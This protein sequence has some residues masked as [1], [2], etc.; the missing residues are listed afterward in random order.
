[1]NLSR[2]DTLFEEYLTKI[3]LTRSQANSIDQMLVETLSLFAT[4]Y[5]GDV[6]IYSQG[7]YAMGTTVRPLTALQSL[8]GTAGEYDVDIVLER[9]TWTDAASALKD[10]RNVLS[11]EYSAK[12][13]TKP[14]ESCERVL[15]S[16][17]AN[18]E[19]AFH[20][21]YV[22]IKSKHP[23]RYASRRSA[24]EWF[25]SDTKKLIE[26]FQDI[27][28]ENTFLPSLI[29]IIK[30]MR[31]NAGLTST[32]SSICITALVCRLYENKSSYADDL[33]NIINGIIRVFNVPHVLL[34]ITLEPLEDDLANRISEAQQKDILKFFIN[35]R[36]ELGE[37]FVNEDI[38]K[39]R[40]VLS[41]S[42]PADINEFPVE[43]EPLRQRQ[44][45][46][47]TDGSLRM[48]GIGEYQSKGTVITR[49]WRKFAG[50]GESLEF[51]ANEYNKRQYGIRW[52]VLNAQGSPRIRGDLFEARGA[53]GGKNSNEYI[54]HETEQYSGKHWVK[55]YVYDKLSKRVVEIGEKFVVEVNK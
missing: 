46:I 49:Q 34:S 41:A 17:D 26:W 35:A 28:E 39:L 15:H 47:E 10:V 44:W 43:L 19:V 27:A 55:Y 22:P 48:T 37:G 21:D 7:S 3:V 5:E 53:G 24:N 29:L 14:R 4:E 42:F 23:T 33:L 12:L 54:N 16:T 25:P 40:S 31:D 30:R 11:D 6:E 18:T 38:A 32:L 13:D 1:M 8:D 2:Y 20:V 51:R 9:A 50:V 52:Q 36:A 45:G